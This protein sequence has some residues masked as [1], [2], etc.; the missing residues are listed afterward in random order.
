MI[1]S[2]LVALILCELK[3]KEVTMKIN[4]I[5]L[6]LTQFL[7]LFVRHQSKTRNRCAKVSLF[8][9][10]SNS[11]SAR[12]S[13]ASRLMGFFPSEILIPS[14]CFSEINV[15]YIPEINADGSLFILSGICIICQNVNIINSASDNS[16]LR[17]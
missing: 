3:Y 2:L 9:S 1:F 13:Y 5:F 14:I 12:R 16:I 4:V 7:A 17:T 15:I 10:L 11:V 8:Y 6:V